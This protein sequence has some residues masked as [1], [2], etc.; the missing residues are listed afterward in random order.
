MATLIGDN[1]DQNVSTALLSLKD[2][3]DRQRQQSS[4]SQGPSLS[5]VNLLPVS[6]VVALVKR[7]KA[8]PPFYLVCHSLH[9]HAQVEALCQKIYFPSEPIPAGSTTLLY[10][11][12]YY[13][14][15]DYMHEEDSE[16]SGFDC[17][18]HA[19][20]CLRK[21]NEDLRSFEM[22]IN[23]TLEKVQAMFIAVSDP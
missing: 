5:D 20:S 18:S 1:L 15:R 10:G 8:S 2:S 13:V 7:I 16:L 11:L 14:I 6:F 12:L 3:L 9:E 19:E 17:A 22:G 23:P 21:F 4:A